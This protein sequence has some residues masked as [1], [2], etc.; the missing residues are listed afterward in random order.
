MDFN[1]RLERAVERGE[2]TKDARFREQQAQSL[3]EAELRTL[4]SQSRLEITDHIERCLKAVADQFPGFEYHSILHDDGWGGRVSR[5][6]IALKS[7]SGGE[8][9]YS[10]MDLIVR[11]FSD[12]QIVELVGK[13]TIRNKEAFNRTNY[14]RLNQLD[15]DSFRDMIDLWVLEY[16]ERF[17]ATT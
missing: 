1:A 5:D 6:D 13:A 4:H 12:A 7:G 10:R 11:P 9:Q 2:Q 16:A 14:Q 8:T 3:S 17:A 15:V